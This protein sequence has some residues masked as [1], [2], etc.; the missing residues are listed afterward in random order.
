MTTSDVIE[1]RIKGEPSVNFIKIRRYFY[2]DI[3]VNIGGG[4][5]SI[6]GRLIKNKK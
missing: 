2:D 3:V 6:S 4:A 1:K 5:K